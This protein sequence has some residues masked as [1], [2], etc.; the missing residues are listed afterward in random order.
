M[1]F[2]L[3][4]YLI[5]ELWPRAAAASSAVVVG[6]IVVIV[7]AILHILTTLSLV[8]FIP[9]DRCEMVQQ[10]LGDVREMWR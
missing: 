9:V 3:I 8:L 6:V 4:D 7:D 10:H 5:Y 2:R 1:G